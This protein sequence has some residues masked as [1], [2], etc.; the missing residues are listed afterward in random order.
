MPHLVSSFLRSS[1]GTIPHIKAVS[2]S[3]NTSR[4][5]SRSASRNTSP[6]A[7]DSEDRHAVKMP[8]LAEAIKKHHR[9]SLHFG[10]SNSKER[11]Q[12]HIPYSPV[13]I[14]WSVESPPVVFHGNAEESTGALVSGQIYLDIKE[15]LVDVE[16]F[17]ASLNM[18]VTHKRPF[19]NN[20]SE[21]QSQSTE[22]EKLTLLAHPVPLRKGKHQFPFSILLPGNLPASMD[23]PVV[24]ISYVMNAEAQF[25][26]AP[27]TPEGTSSIT[28]TKF[29]RIIDVK[30]T[31]T[32]PLY[33]HNSVRVFPPT[34]IKA[35]ASYVSVIHPSGNNKMTLKLD[36]LMTHN[37]RVKTV[38]LWKLKK[39]TWKLEETIK[40]VA[41]ACERHNPGLAESANKG[42][43]RSETRVIGEKNLTEGW[44]SDYTGVDGIVDMEFEF[45][46][47]QLKP[48]SNALKYACDTKTQ[49]GTEVTHSLL[50]ELVV[51]KEYAQEGKTHISHQTGTGRILRMHFAVVLTDN[52]GLSVSWD[53][54]APPVYQDVPPSPPEYAQDELPIEYDDLEELVAARATAPN[55]RRGSQELS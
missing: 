2:R 36:G 47:N 11:Q 50:L 24:S 4:S 32:E 51:S 6:H 42:L 25:L 48:H 45:C 52:G 49:D 37:E 3:R 19:Q 9:L 14:D 40:T 44:K 23:T 30:R 21:C 18:V 35:A 28:T 16:S 26:T 27:T 54:E 8:D 12:Q 17:T 55:S 22:V 7:S 29:E 46:V 43:P 31:L 5:N 13:V 53:N 38:D 1:T 34:N 10:R 15:D 39:L 20:C 33:P 41:P